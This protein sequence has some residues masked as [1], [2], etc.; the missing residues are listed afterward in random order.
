MTGLHQWIAWDNIPTYRDSNSLPNPREI[1]QAAMFTSLLKAR[2]DI[3]DCESVTK[4]ERIIKLIKAKVAKQDEIC[5]ERRRP[6]KR[7]YSFR[8]LEY[9]VILELSEY[10]PVIIL[11][12]VTGIPR[13]SFYS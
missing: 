10:F 3:L 13:S 1:T 2:L 11:C 9:Q 5:G 12:R 6:N 7:I 4:K 8:Q